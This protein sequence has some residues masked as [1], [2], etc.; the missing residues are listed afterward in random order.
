[1]T[2]RTI[3]FLDDDP[4]VRIAR[5]VLCNEP[6]AGWLKDYFAPEA[7]DLAPLVDAARGI[8][9][10]DGVH[11]QLADG[12]DPREFDP[13]VIVFRRG[14]VSAECIAGCVQLKLIQRLGERPDGI[15]L[16]AARSAGVAVS[17]LPRRTLDFTAEHALL[18]MLAL[19]KKLTVSDRLVRASDAPAA[20]GVNGVAYNWPGIGGLTGLHGKTLGVVGLGEVGTLVVKLARAFGMNVIYT[21]RKPLSEAEENTLGA[22]F[23]TLPGLLER[24]DFVSLHAANLPENRGMMGRA[25]FAAMRAQAFFV[26]TSRGALV[27]EDALFDAL[28]SGA[29][30]GAGL[31]VHGVEPRSAN[32]RFCSLDNVVLTPHVAGGSRAGLLPEL[33]T[34]IENC[35]AA[36]N[37]AAFVHR[38]A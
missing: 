21:K 15:D 14:V 11:I 4:V 29:I 16:D 34:L 18:L 24:A 22:S 1:M 9:R 2:A 23:D 3:L 33:R 19:G 36:F 13:A 32:D 12:T 17:C 35:R 6:D 38:I 8:T 26:N 20:A 27:D 28:R 5:S 37:G 31:D 10:E 25:E 7:P 30:A